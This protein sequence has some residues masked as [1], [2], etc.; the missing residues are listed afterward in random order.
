MCYFLN[1]IVVVV[2]C[3]FLCKMGEIRSCCQ[4]SKG[5]SKG[6]F[7]V[8]FLGR[9]KGTVGVEI[10]KKIRQVFDS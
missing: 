4:G 7:I 2:Y 3:Y 8:M 10:Q 1:D 5:S 6:N 9:T